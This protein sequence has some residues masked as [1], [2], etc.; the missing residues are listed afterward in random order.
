MSKDTPDKLKFR[1]IGAW[2][3]WLEKNH[4]R[5]QVAWVV[6]KNKGRARKRGEEVPFDMHMIR[7]E[8]LCWGWVDSLLRNIDE[9]EYMVKYTPRK[10]TS[11]W[12]EHNKKR[13]ERLIA[14]GRM[15][16]AGM[17]TI[18]VAKENGMWDRG[19]KLPEV[20]DSLPGA[21]LQAFQ[22]NPGAR[23]HYFGM[24]ETGRKQYNIWINMAKR[25]ETT[26]KRVEE[27]IRLLEK[28]EELGLK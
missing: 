27:S 2:R 28:G 16:P 17:R 9:E 6:F 20:D 5:E 21:L 23:D 15:T 24:R 11:T 13:V 1:N 19:I 12:S 26:R 3:D 7:D 4:D 10:P 18:E 25:A 8:A 14:E 22:S